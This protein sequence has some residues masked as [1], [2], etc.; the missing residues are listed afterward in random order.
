VS[1]PPI[2]MQG[3]ALLLELQV[4]PG[5]ARDGFVGLHGERL[6][7]RITAPPV[8]GRAN[9]HLLEFLA[10]TFDVPRARVILLRGESGRSKSVRIEAPGTIPA[11]IRE[12][13][14]RSAAD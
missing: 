9:R 5:A 4:Q 1:T 8:D 12:L 3:A 6:K 13:I 2:R 11:D 10:S 14:G 7:V